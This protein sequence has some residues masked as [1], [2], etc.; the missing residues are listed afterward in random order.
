VEHLLHLVAYA[1]YLHDR[2]GSP[3]AGAYSFRI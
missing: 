1:Q 3:P 2:S